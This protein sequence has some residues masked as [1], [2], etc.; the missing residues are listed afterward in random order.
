MTELEI[1]CWGYSPN[2]V[3]HKSVLSLAG[4][5]IGI[6]NGHLLGTYCMP[7]TVPSLRNSTANE[8]VSFHGADVPSEG[9][10]VTEALITSDQVRGHCTGE[11]LNQD[12][13]GGM[14]E[15]GLGKEGP[16]T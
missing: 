6:L 11:R 8:L 1:A 15:E 4:L 13:V 16:P 5:F 2:S 9:Q 12:H 10:V 7:K 3:L 14:A